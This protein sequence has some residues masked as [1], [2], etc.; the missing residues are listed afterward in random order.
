MQHCKYHIATALFFIC[1]SGMIVRAQSLCPYNIDF[2]SG[3]LIG[4]ECRTGKVESISGVN[5]ITW[6]ASGVNTDNHKIIPAIGAGTDPYGGFPQAC[7]NGSGYSVRLGNNYFST[8]SAEGMFYTFT[9]PDTAS[10]FSILF[11]YAVVFQDPQHN[12]DEQPRFRA[13]VFNVTDNEIVNCSNF[14]FT[15]SALLP[16]FEVSALDPTVIYKGWTPVTLNLSGYAGKTIRLEFITSDC[17]FTGHFGY[18][19]IDVNSSCSDAIAG[20]IVCP[21][22]A[23]VS[24][25]APYG[26]RNYTWYTDNTY[27]TVL[28]TTQTVHIAPAPSIGSV[29]PV[30]VEPY[31]GFGCIDTIQAVVRSAAKPDADAGPD[32]EVCESSQAQLGAAAVDYYTY[33]WSP[34]P[35][36]INASTSNVITLP[37]LTSPTDFYLT[38]THQLTGCKDYDTVTV[39]PIQVVDTA[40]MVLGDTIFCANT[41]V[42][43]LLQLKSTNGSFKWYENGQLVNDAVSNQF[44]PAPVTTAIYHAV[45]SNGLCVGYTR[46]V[47][48]KK[49]PVPVADF[50]V[51]HTEQ[52][53][54]GWIEVLNKSTVPAGTINNYWWK[55]SDGRQFITSD[56]SVNFASAGE[57]S[58]F[59][60]AVTKEGCVDS[61]FRKI[62]I[63]EKCEVYVPTGFTPGDDGKNDVF[64]P[65]FY[66]I[67]KLRRFSVYDRN[68]TMVYTTQKAGEGWDG[69]VKGKKLSTAVFVW[70]LEYETTQGKA[71]LLK[72]TVTLIR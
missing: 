60:K 38:V 20:N 33:E 8:I 30:V 59:L 42:N 23:N 35:L 53:L 58:I 1:M 3:N 72:G 41:P 55:L 37:G 46:P 13:N 45:I 19:Y 43:T 11:N 36:L 17:T 5:T 47:S 26:F 27:T 65:E 66:G 71:V 24:L 25:T 31:P 34:V 7:P 67:L 14:D 2:E 64:K 61:T 9:I 50:L 69:K 56:L 39:T 49:I 32:I 22:A 29:F 48:I 44:H 6:L 57:Y 18:A 21:G 68:G 4:W 40:M 54:N 10:V 15:A 52:C 28:S 62:N 70:M 63:V 12:P 16:G 51:S